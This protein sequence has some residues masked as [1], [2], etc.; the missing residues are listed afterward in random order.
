MRHALL[1]TTVLF[2]PS[3]RAEPDA[4]RRVIAPPVSPGRACDTSKA[5]FKVELR[6]VAIEKLTE[7]V[8][9]A[10]CTTFDLPAQP[11]RGM[12]DHTTG[13]PSLTGKQLLEIFRAGLIGQGYRTEVEGDRVRV[14]D[15][16]GGA[17]R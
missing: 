6:N 5:K 2:L 7:I 14:V 16:S 10:S 12:I 17:S 11:L 3:A 15:V 8:A 13:H 9:A 1:L 4:G